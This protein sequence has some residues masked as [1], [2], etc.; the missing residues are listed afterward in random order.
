MCGLSL[1]RGDPRVRR[2]RPIGLEAQEDLEWT[3]DQ[4]SFAWNIHSLLRCHRATEDN[5]IDGML[6]HRLSFSAILTSTPRRRR[7]WLPRSSTA[8]SISE[9]MFSG[10]PLRVLVSA[11]KRQAPNAARRRRH[12]TPRQGGT[13]KKLRASM[14]TSL[15]SSQVC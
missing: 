6:F 12:T 4:S 9:R 11:T 13:C 3:S 8:S 1:D 15:Q 14:S 10:T 5:A 7:G 2:R